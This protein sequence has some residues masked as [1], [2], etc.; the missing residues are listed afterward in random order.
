MV[1]YDT[2]PERSLQLID[3]AEIVG[4]LTD[5]RASLLRAQVYS[6]SSVLQR[7]D[8]V[9]QIC[10]MLLQHDSVQANASCRQ[11]VLEVLVN[12]SRMRHDDE[13]W[14]HWAVQLADL[15]REQ[16]YETEALPRADPLRSGFN[17]D[18]QN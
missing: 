16:G 7:Q 10:R 11:S 13:Q 9:Q 18:G 17:G 14:M 5:F 1:F 12:A 15:L 8:T 4:N 3:S 6:Y 2:L